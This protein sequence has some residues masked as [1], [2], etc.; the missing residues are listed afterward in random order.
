MANRRPIRVLIVEDDYLV[1]LVIRRQV[2]DLGAEVVG[3]A[4]DGLEALELAETLRPDVILMDVRM[5]RMDGIE[6]TRCLRRRGTIPI[7]ILTAD[8]VD[9]VLAAAR[10]AGACAFL[11]KIPLRHDLERALAGALAGAQDEIPL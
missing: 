1:T 6:A 3:E 7:I 9:E 11:S 10:A 2:G 8:D 5:P 4:A